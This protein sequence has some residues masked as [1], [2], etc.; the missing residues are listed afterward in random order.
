M[1]KGKEIKGQKRKGKIGIG[2]DKDIGIRN[3]KE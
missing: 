3:R 2:E 1:R